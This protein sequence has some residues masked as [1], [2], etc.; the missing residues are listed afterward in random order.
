[1]AYMFDKLKVYGSHDTNI[2]G[3]INH[4]TKIKTEGY[5]LAR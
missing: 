3:N 4:K 2:T 1:M 5:H